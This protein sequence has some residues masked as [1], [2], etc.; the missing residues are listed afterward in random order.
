ME[1]EIINEEI[2]YHIYEEI[3]ENYGLDELYTVVKDL[4]KDTRDKLHTLS[5]D[6][7]NEKLSS[8]LNN[9]NMVI[10]GFINNWPYKYSNIDE[11]YNYLNGD[12]PFHEL[13]ITFKSYNVYIR[14]MLY[15]IASYN[16]NDYLKLNFNR[17]NNH[18][19]YDKFKKVLDAYYIGKLEEYILFLN[20]SGE[21]KLTHMI[22]EEFD[23]FAGYSL[24]EDETENMKI[25]NEAL[26]IIN[27]NKVVDNQLTLDLR[28]IK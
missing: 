18:I 1:K 12:L 8:Y 22:N 24:S 28:T 14:K 26:N 17:F 2:I 16:N 15:E 20:E 9:I 10:D 3:T 7:N 6:E 13:Y 25:M 11:L 5:V 19:F 27:K 4:N 21:E 23:S